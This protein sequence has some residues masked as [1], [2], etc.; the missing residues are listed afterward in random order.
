MRRGWFERAAPRLHQGN[1]RLSRSF[2][3]PLPVFVGLMFRVSWRFLLCQ[4]IDY[5]SPKC[6]QRQDNA[7]DQAVKV[8]REDLPAWV[9]GVAYRMRNRSA[10]GHGY[11]TGRLI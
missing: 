7:K 6:D 1:V 5:A 4:Q 2:L 9:A 3:L 8:H 10:V 11:R